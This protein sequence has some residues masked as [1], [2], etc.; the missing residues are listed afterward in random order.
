MERCRLIL[1]SLILALLGSEQ[2]A[3]WLKREWVRLVRYKGKK[4]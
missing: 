1:G 2:D 4:V 3:A